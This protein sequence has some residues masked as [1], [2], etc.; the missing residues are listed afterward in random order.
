[1]SP[2]W[3]HGWTAWMA[4]TSPAMTG[5]NG[6]IKTG[7]SGDD[8]DLG[9]QHLVE[10]AEGDVG[11]RRARPRAHAHRYRRRFR[12]EQGAEI[13]GDESERPGADARGGRRLPALGVEFDRARSGR[14]ARQGRR[15]RAEGCQA[16]R[17][18]QPMDGLAALAR[19]T[20]D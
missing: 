14:E 10:R 2:S 18:G 15:D 20:G 13:P 16:A 5:Y 12:Q 17:A 6:R 19:G 9:A 3:L 7:E 4:G 11:G 8:Q 1:A